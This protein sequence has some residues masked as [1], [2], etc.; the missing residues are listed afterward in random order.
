MV[1]KHNHTTIKRTRYGGGPVGVS[2]VLEE[3]QVRVR[4]NNTVPREGHLSSDIDGEGWTPPVRLHSLCV[5]Q[6]LARCRRVLLGPVVA[7]HTPPAGAFVVHLQNAGRCDKAHWGGRTNAR[8]RPVPPGGGDLSLAVGLVLL[9][10]KVVLSVKEETHVSSSSP[11]V[12]SLVPSQA[13]SSGM[14]LMERLQ[15]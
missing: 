5:S 8:V 9:P 4:S 3:N 2:G 7:A 12:Q 6:L 13:L 14:N 11:S 10:G 15:K 1:R